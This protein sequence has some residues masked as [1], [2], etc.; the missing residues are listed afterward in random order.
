MKCAENEQNLTAQEGGEQ[1]L[2]IGVC[3]GYLTRDRR[4]NPFSMITLRV[5]LSPY[6]SG[7]PSPLTLLCT[8]STPK[9]HRQSPP[10]YVHSA[11]IVQKG[12]K[13]SAIE[14]SSREPAAKILKKLG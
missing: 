11:E 5:P 4:T 7:S 13:K 1:W 10:P 14:V 2:Q 3:R 8:L 12:C 6:I 9:Q